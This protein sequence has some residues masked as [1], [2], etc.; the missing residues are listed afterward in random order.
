MTP[1]PHPMDFTGRLAKGWLFVHRCPAARVR[2]LHP[3]G[4]ELI[5]HEGFAF[6]NVV[7]GRV[8]GFRHAAWPVWLPWPGQDFWQVSYRLLVRHREPGGRATE[9]LH[10]HHSECDD[11]WVALGGNWLTAFRYA[12][13]P[14][15]ITHQRDDRWTYL[16]VTT[17]ED[18]AE[19]V[20]DNELAPRQAPGSPFASLAEAAEVLQYRP[21][22]LDVAPDGTARTIQVERDTRDWAPRLRQPVDQRWPRLERFG[23]EPELCFELPQ[24]GFRWR[25][26]Q[27]LGEEAPAPRPAPRPKPEAVLA[28][29]TVHG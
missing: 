2:H 8:E 18:W 13:R 21:V 28:V 20:V 12:R 27:P 10:F 29:R 16:R 3:P 23:A 4:L 25:L 24:I 19:A 1:A 14:A 9:G 11:P 17:R 5:E 7:A 22:V 6:W 15:R 26:G